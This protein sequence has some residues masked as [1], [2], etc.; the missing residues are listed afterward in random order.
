MLHA[1]AV[2]AA[3]PPPRTFHKSVVVDGVR[4]AYREAGQADAPVVLLLHGFPSSSHMFRDLI[5]RLAA[6]HRVIAP[7]YPGFG[8][9]DVPAVGDFPYT[10]AAIADRIDGFTRAVGADRYVIYMQDYGGPV[11][12]RLALAHPERVR[13]LVV[14]NA[15]A[16]VEGWNPEVVGQIGPYWQERTPATE[17]PVRALLSPETTRFQYAHGETRA[18]RL[19][20]DAWIRDQA[21]LDRPGN[22]A[23]QLEMLFN[24]RDN[25]AQYPFWKT[26]LSDHRPPMLIVWGRNDPFFTI[27]GVD[28]FRELVPTATVRLYDAGHFAL[29]T[30]LDEI[31]TEM[32]DFLGG[33][34]D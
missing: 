28:H 14:Q 26:W 31:A 22:D 12:L 20:P 16:N 21:G 4:I 10:F 32:L 23:V 33:L 25:V 34:P 5:P 27:A 17:A 7:D 15:V 29:E 30:H 6:T 11:G 18:D 2:A 3:P 13:G 19:S 1:S 9:S 8:D 24:Y